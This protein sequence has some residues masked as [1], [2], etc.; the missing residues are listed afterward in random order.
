VPLHQHGDDPGTLPERAVRT[1]PLGPLDRA[2]DRDGGNLLA[3]LPLESVERYNR[4]GQQY[5]GPVVLVIDALCYSTT[6]IFTAGFQDHRIGKVLGTSRHTGA[7]G[8]N[9]WH[10]RQFQDILPA[11][12][13][14]VP[15]GA[16]FSAAVRRCTRV[17]GQAG[18]PVKDLG[19]APD[20][21]V[22]LM[23]RADVL[24]ENIDLIAKA[25]SLLAAETVHSLAAEVDR[26]HPPAAVIKARAQNISR[27]DLYRNGRPLTSVD[28][29]DGAAAVPIPDG[30][31][32]PGTLELRGF[33]GG[34]L[35]AFT[36]V[37]L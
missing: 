32:G 6:D 27:I 12:F 37:A 30:L 34:N 3:R 23:T 5:Q 13:G 19:V 26:S 9:V 31:R 28:V 14:P 15:K 33:E 21:D 36:K 1:R 22:Y 7:G 24:E 29:R 8:A 2:G 20:G 17:N 25:A 4:V 11:R 16:G 18:V 35:A 10:Y